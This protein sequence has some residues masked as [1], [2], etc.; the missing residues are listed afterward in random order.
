VS[1]FNYLDRMV[2]AILLE[3]IRRDL[4]LSDTQLGLIAGFAFAILYAT[5]GLPLA[6][7]AD[8]RSR[9]ALISI[10]LAVWSA[11]TALTGLVR[12]F[13]ELFV[14]RMALGVGEA[15]C[16][17]AAHSLLGDLYPRERRAMAISIYQAGGALGLSIGAAFAGVVAELWGWR[18]A[19]MAI[20][21]LGFPLAPLL[22]FTVREPVRST[23]HA[24]ASAEPV[25][26]T[27]RHL[28][29]RPPLRHLALGVSIAGMASVGLLQWLPT[30][31]IRIHG[32][33]LT[34]AGF[35]VG[36]VKGVAGVL[37]TVLGG[38]VVSRL[39]RRDHRWELWWPMI[40]YA[41][42]PL[43]MAL[44]LTASD[45]A[46]ALGL[47]LV[48][49]FVAAT[50]AGVVLSALQT[51]AEAHRRATALAIV[52]LISSL[53]SVGL[54]PVVVGALSDLLA[55]RLGDES[56]RYALMLIGGAAF[57]GAVH[58]WLAARSSERWRVA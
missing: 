20:G 36:A 17:P 25:L 48:E 6:R 28:L 34:E 38:A 1:F 53:V 21:V 18:A 10:C 58:L 9:I 45:W 22:F 57:W 26:A 7:I 24:G 19:L 47:L 14:V 27:L 11:M 50:A 55:P 13:A 37:G 43:L 23:G 15:G 2:I 44:F 41:I 12:N 52:M 49:T 8:R 30:Y 33:S 35:Y 56:L 3:P 5:L 32:L 46:V 39:G 40:V 16:A 31:F 4:H 54:G 29:A 51:Y 42:T